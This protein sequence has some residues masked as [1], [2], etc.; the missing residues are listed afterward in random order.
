MKRYLKCVA[1]CVAAPIIIG[2]WML[3]NPRAIWAQA[4]K[5]W[6]GHD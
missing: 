5:E 4:K 1:L 2:A 3:F 6:F